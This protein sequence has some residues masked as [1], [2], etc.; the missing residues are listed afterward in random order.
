MSR[1]D[2]DAALDPAGSVASRA[3]RGGP[4]PDAVTTSLARM[5]ETHGDHEAELAARRDALAVAETN[6]TEAVDGYA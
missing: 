6:L 4:A 3:S 1:E 2:I 5:S